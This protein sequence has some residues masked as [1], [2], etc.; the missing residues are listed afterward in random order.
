MLLSDL[1]RTSNW[2]VTGRGGDVYF[3]S[4]FEDLAH[5]AD[6]SKGEIV[7]FAYFGDGLVALEGGFDDSTYIVRELERDG[8]RHG[9]QR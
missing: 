5:S 1:R 6:L 4:L 2:L 9:R 7:G 8:C 3:A